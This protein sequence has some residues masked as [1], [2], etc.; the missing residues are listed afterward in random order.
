VWLMRVDLVMGRSGLL[1]I[2]I[3]SP[4]MRQVHPRDLLQVLRHLVRREPAGLAAAVRLVRVPGP[5]GGAGAA[6]R[7]GGGPGGVAVAGPD[8]RQ[9]DS[10]A[11]CRA[12]A[13]AWGGYDCV[14]RGVMRIRSSS[15]TAKCPAQ[16]V[17]LSSAAT[18]TRA[19][20][21]G[22]GIEIRKRMIPF[23]A[24]SPNRNA[25]SPKSLSKVTRIRP[26]A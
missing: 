9:A 11:Q 20:C 10:P 6:G 22:E 4:I 19:T 16:S 25:N 17:R 23:E 18:A 14:E 24:G 5:R 8:A 26:S 13:R 3:S 1:L 2:K 12:F 7:G 21:A 15:T